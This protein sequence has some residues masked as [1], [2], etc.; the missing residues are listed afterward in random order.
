MNPQN[1]I[2]GDETGIELPQKPIDDEALNEL[3]RKAK[4]SRYKEYAE[5]RAKAQDRI[6]FYKRFLPNG[7]LVGT[8]SPE[9]LARKWELA[10]ILIAEF[11]GLFGE[12]E[13]AT[14]ILKDE[15]SE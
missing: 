1:V 3:R 5:L 11:E 6:D 13:N 15:F 12:N 8:T 9:D 4:Y 10:N 14:Q 2:L 7:E